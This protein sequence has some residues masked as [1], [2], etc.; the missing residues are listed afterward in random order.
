MIERLLPIDHH[1]LG[2]ERDFNHW[3]LH[4]FEIVP[5]IREILGILVEEDGKTM[6]LLKRLEKADQRGDAVG[7]FFAR[8]KADAVEPAVWIVLG[9]QEP[10]PLVAI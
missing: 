7:N 2:A 10:L 3:L 1:K 6:R 8:G 5:D 9:P 4:A